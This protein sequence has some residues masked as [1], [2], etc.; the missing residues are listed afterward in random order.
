MWQP[1]LGGVSKIGQ[2]T[3]APACS[4]GGALADRRVDASDCSLRRRPAAPHLKAD[5]P[6]TCIRADGQHRAAQVVHLQAA[7][8]HG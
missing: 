3:Q 4:K 6:G 2:A 8:G 5:A 7:R 1:I